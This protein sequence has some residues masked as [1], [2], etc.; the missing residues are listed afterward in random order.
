MID[1]GRGSLHMGLDTH[2]DKTLRLTS[3]IQMGLLS[4]PELT[5]F[6][7]RDKNVVTVFS[8]P[9]YYMTVLIS[10]SL[11]F[12]ILDAPLMYQVAYVFLVISNFWKSMKRGMGMCFLLQ[13]QSWI[14][15]GGSRKSWGPN[16]TYDL[17]G[18]LR[19]IKHYLILDQGDFLVHFTDIALDELDKAPNEISVEKLQSLLDLALRS[20]AAAADPLHEDLSEKLDPET[21]N[22]IGEEFMMEGLL[23]SNST[24]STTSIITGEEVQSIHETSITS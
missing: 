7:W 23:L 1:A 15:I 22:L 18:K 4:S 21:M 20:T 14:S 17:I 11:F 3:T 5:S 8:A 12:F 16:N 2:S 13:K 6:S 19:S 10:V 24:T 9:N